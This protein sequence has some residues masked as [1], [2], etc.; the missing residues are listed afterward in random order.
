MSAM[1]Q[2]TCGIHEE[3]H[4]HAS[5]LTTVSE[6]VN[7]SV[8]IKDQGMFFSAYGILALNIILLEELYQLRC[9]DLV[10]MT[11]SALTML[12]ISE[13]VDFTEG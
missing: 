2:W 10:F 11:V 6:G 12:I 9:F 4:Q 7:L 3:V 5:I 1:T 8:F 13:G